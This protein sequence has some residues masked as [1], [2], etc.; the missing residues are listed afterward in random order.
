[1]AEKGYSLFMPKFIII[2]IDGQR[3]TDNRRDRQK[4]EVER[5]GGG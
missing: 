4:E 1:M 5:E 3:D 2:G